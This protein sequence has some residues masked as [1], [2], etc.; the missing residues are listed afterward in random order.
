LQ[1]ENYPV[2]RARQAFCLRPTQPSMMMT[3]QVIPRPD[4]GGNTRQISQVH[5][6]KVVSVCSRSLLS[7][8]YH[9]LLILRL[10]QCIKSTSGP[11]VI[12]DVVEQNSTIHRGCAILGASEPRLGTRPRIFSEFGRHGWRPP[13][14]SME[15]EAFR[16]VMDDEPP[17]IHEAGPHA[18]SY[19][20]FL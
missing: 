2:E 4:P 9:S 7:Q 18:N 8:P 12:H 14:T 6:A 16:N 1:L 19:R 20:A 10:R 17:C 3:V 11:L 5:R 13:C 15:R